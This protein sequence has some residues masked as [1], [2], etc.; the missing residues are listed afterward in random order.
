M[1][2]APFRPLILVGFAVLWASASHALAEPYNPYSNTPLNFAPLKAD[3][4]I[5]WGTFHKSADLQRLYE[6]LW[7]TGACRGTRKA[8]IDVVVNN[9][10]QVDELPE[11]DFKGVVQG[12]SGSLAGGVLAFSTGDGGSQN[13]DK[14]FIA[15]L[16]P[17]GVS[18]VA[19]AGRISVDDLKPGMMVRFRPVVDERGRGTTPVKAITVVTPGKGYKPE[20]IEPGRPDTVVGTIVS[21]KPPAVVIQLHAGSVRRLV[22][23]MADDVEATVEAARIDL[24]APGDEV[25]ITGRLWTGEGAAAAGTVFASDVTV[26]KRSPTPPATGSGTVAAA[27]PAAR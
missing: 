3:G 9:R 14:I 1:T 4:T 8:I 27:G 22:C 10:M 18:R 17:A 12:V 19:V 11:R 24:V 25:T 13:H 7:A 23:R 2:P 20:G 15:H 16:H 5:H 21:V 26:T 6:R